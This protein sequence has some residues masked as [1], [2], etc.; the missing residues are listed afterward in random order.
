MTLALSLLAAVSFGLS[1]FVGGLAARRASAWAVALVS[2]LGGAAGAGAVALA[3]GGDPRGSDWAWAALA[4]VGNGV[5]AAFL[6][7]GLS[8]GRMG[9]VAP[10]SG[11]GA[12]VLPVA[13]GLVAGDRPAALAWAG[14][15]VALP[16]IWLVAR[17][18]APATAATPAGPSGLVDGVLAGLGFGVLFAAVGQ[19]REDAGFAPLVLVQ[20][21]GVVVVV[22]VALG[23]RASLAPRR[24]GVVGAAVLTGVLGVSASGLF[25]VATQGGSLTIAA[26]VTSLYP[27]FTVLL[28]A[29]V[30]RER[31]HRGQAVGLVLCGIAVGLI[32]AG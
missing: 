1:D 17:E 16:A 15:V 13:A 28:A 26:V 4:G 5:G 31:V 3:V 30:L 29:L 8:G 25:L 19:V 23:L 14:I 6:Y 10:V 21:V 18:P 27:A 9:V 32:A 12:A 20:V 22:A 7:R 24:V 2:Q 11:V